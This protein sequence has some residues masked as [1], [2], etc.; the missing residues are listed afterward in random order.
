M[1][2]LSRRTPKVQLPLTSHPLDPHHPLSPYVLDASRDYQ[3]PQTRRSS[4]PRRLARREWYASHPLSWHERPPPRLRHA[5]LGGEVGAHGELAHELE[6]VS[7][8]EPRC[9]FDLAQ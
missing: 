7:L 8:G 5:D 4:S 3:R 2:S 1:S 9:R 6:V